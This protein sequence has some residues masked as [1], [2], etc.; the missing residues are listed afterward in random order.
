VRHYASAVATTPAPP[1]H[2]STAPPPPPP[3]QFIQ[4]YPP[5]QPPSYKL[6]ELRKTQLHRQY[7]SL[8]KS[9]PLLLLFQHNNLTAAEL[10]GIRRELGAA[11]RKVDEAEGTAYAGFVKLQIV[12]TGIFASALNVVT[13]FDGSAPAITEGT[14]TGTGTGTGSKATLTHGL[15][16]TAWKAGKAGAKKQHTNNTNNNTAATTPTTTNNNGD[17]HSLSPL[18]KGPVVLLTLPTVS[19]AHLKAALSILSPSE[20]FPA[21]KRRVNPTYHEPAVQSGLQK[22][23]LLGAR[24][25]GR[26]LDQD[27]ARWVGGIEGGITGLRSQLVYLLQQCGMGV[28]GVLEAAGKNL[29]FSLETR[30]SVLEEEENP[31]HKEDGQEKPTS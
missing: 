5:T 31:T 7:Q 14:G 15:S 6:P 27:G 20:H 24:A 3:P 16:V 4:R 18:L 9:T 11:L 30:R 26:V 22:L 13:F 2:S 21:P 28:S 19:P 25:E 17:Q 8:I 1:I 10:N 29:W 23:M 12:Q